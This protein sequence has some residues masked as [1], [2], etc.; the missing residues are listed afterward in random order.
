MGFEPQIRKIL[1][2]VRPDRQLLMWSATWPE[3]V[4]GLANDFFGESKNDY[5]HLNIGST[6]LQANENITQCIEVISQGEKNNCLLDLLR[7]IRTEFEGTTQPRILIFAMTKREVDFL[8]KL[9]CRE[10]FRAVGIH[11]DKTQRMRDAV[12]QNS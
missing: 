9:V 7:G 6:K 10:G 12:S 1:G 3:E 8:V 4:R 11:G 5:I 2:Q